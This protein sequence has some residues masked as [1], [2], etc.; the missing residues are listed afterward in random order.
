MTLRD[1]TDSEPFAEYESLR[2]TG[3]RWD[4]VLEAWLVTSYT[5][6]LAV[7]SD[8]TRFRHPYAETADENMR[9]LEG[10]RQLTMLHGDEHERV[11]RF[12]LDALA[13]TQVAAWRSTLIRP[14]VDATIGRLRPSGAAELA[15]E[16]CEQVPVRVIAAVMGLPWDDDS[17]IAQCKHLMAAK[18]AFLEGRDRD[19]DGRLARDGAAAIQELN[20]LLRPY[21]AERRDAIGSDLISALW[22]EGPRLLPDWGEQDVVDNVQGTFFGGADT[23][24]H[25]LANGLFT[26]LTDPPLQDRLRDLDTDTINHFA[27][28]ILRLYGAVQFRPRLATTETN[29]DGAAIRPADPIYAVTSAANRDPA[30]YACSEALDLERRAPRRHLAFGFGER[31]CVG[32]ALARQELR[33]VVAAVLTQLPD[34]RLDPDGEPPSF[35]GFLLRS[36]RPLPVLFTAG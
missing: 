24:S 17:W 26:L 5:G 19:H 6:C 7:L 12:W 25:L 11:R 21:V 10:R 32:H 35:R 4:P 13:P 23:T 30:K 29:L 9:E 31:S 16:L 2:A 22:R 8:K 27:E 33:E 3:A 14:I 15:E 18:V 34:V 28:E 1:T 20:E 36:F